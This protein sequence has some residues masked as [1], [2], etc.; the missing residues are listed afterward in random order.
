MRR[1]GL[2]D[3]DAPSRRK[4]RRGKKNPPAPSLG[5]TIATILGAAGVGYVGYKLWTGPTAPPPPPRQ[6]AP[7]PQQRTWQQRT[8]TTQQAPQQ[9]PG[10]MHGEVVE[11]S[12][13]GI[14]V[15]N[16]PAES[17]MRTA[18][19]RRHQPQL[20]MQAPGGTGGQGQ[21][22]TESFSGDSDSSASL[23]GERF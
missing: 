13:N 6:P 19:A 4:K 3:Q 20:M 1:R 18:Q 11:Y 16:L 12:Q 22:Q 17:A 7:A 21:V 14:P 23:G 5:Q 10:G 8:V 9:L 2:V 15:I